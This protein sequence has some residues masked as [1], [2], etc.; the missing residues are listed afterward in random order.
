MPWPEGLNVSCRCLNGVLLSVF[1]LL[2]QNRIYGRKIIMPKL[3]ATTFL[4]SKELNL[5]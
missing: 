2:S 1:W 3:D 4:S 5:V